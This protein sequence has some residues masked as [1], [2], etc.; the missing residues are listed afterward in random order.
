MDISFSTVYG[1]DQGLHK[2][3][4]LPVSSRLVL[5]KDF[6]LNKTALATTS[7]SLMATLF[8]SIATNFRRGREVKLV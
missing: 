7:S 5:R 8:V 4:F 6:V 2:K 1:H 3:G